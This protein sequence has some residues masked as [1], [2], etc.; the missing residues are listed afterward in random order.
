MILSLIS[1]FF[2]LKNQIMRLL[3]LFKASKMSK[4]DHDFSF[5]FEKGLSF[6]FFGKENFSLTKRKSIINVFLLTL[7]KLGEV[8]IYQEIILMTNLLL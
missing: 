1:F 7:N 2:F 3:K 4:N 8:K 6:P 5:Y